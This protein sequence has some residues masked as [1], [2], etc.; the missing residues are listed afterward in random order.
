MDLSK[1]KFYRF[2]EIV[3]IPD[4]KLLNVIIAARHKDKW[5]MCRHG[6]R[7]TW[8]FPGGGREVG[9]AIAEAAKRELYEETG[10]IKFALSPICVYALD[11]E[12]EIKYGLLYYADVDKLSVLPDSEMREVK[13]MDDVPVDLTYPYTLHDIL[14]VVKDFLINKKQQ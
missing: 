13:L 8:E 14:P 10:A 1:I 2:Y 7:D 5:V 9:E 12:H 11:I 4:D 6:E 3:E